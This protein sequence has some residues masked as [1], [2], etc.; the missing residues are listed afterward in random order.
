M[1]RSTSRPLPP[2]RWSCASGGRAPAMRCRTSWPSSV[3]STAVGARPRVVVSSADRGDQRIGPD[4]HQSARRRRRPGRRIVGRDR[5]R[6]TPRRTSPPRGVDG[7]LRT[8]P[9][10]DRVARTPTASGDR[11]ARRL[12]ARR[13]RVSAGERGHDLVDRTHVEVVP[14][15]GDLTIGRGSNTPTTGMS[16]VWSPR[17]NRSVRSFRTTLPVAASRWTMNSTVSKP[18][19]MPPANALI[20]SG[21]KFLPI[22][23]LSYSTSSVTSS[24][25]LSRSFEQNRRM[26]S[27][28]VSRGVIGPTLRARHDPGR[29]DRMRSDPC[30]RGGRVR[31]RR[32]AARRCARGPVREQARGSVSSEA[33]CDRAPSL[34]SFWRAA[35]WYERGERVLAGRRSRRSRRVRRVRER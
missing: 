9:S 6:G 15:E 25:A 27:L 2:H 28:T 12:S 32:A 31:R 24:H 4:G 19:T 29:T 22:G 13:S 14:P 20:P 8:G 33:T 7:T 5:C 3:R 35:A 23:T 17:T 10:G 21:P 1:A 11:D 18:P 26:N 30:D 16:K 34:T